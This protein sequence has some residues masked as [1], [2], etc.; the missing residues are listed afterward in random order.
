M[1]TVTDFQSLLGRVCG[2]EDLSAD[3]MGQALEAMFQ[4][5]MPDGQIGLFLSALTSKGETV[6]ELVGA[7]TCLRRHMTRIHSTHERFVDTCG[8]GGDGLGTFNVSTAAAIV[9]A[10]AGLPVAKHGNRKVTSK[11]G[12]ADVLTQLGV[13]I[14]AGVDVVESCLR[15]LGICFCFAPLLHP[16]LARVA[17]VRRQLGVPTI[18]NLLGP[19]ANPASAPFQLLGVGREN[20]RPL[21]ANALARL[22]VRRALVVWGEDGLDEVT[23]SAPTRVS[24]VRDG[25]VH[26]FVWTAADFGVREAPLAAL[27]VEG[28]AES[29]AMIHHVLSGGNGAARNI[30]LVN[31]AA[32]LWVAGVVDSLPAGVSRAA[33]AIDEGHAAQLIKRLAAAT[34]PTTGP[35]AA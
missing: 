2:G 29:A 25:I 15:E 26:E 28:P 17:A 10:A 30:V 13:T 9:T 35:A 33:K 14:E 23:L 27:L 4:G 1:A 18:F 7:A 32:A 31:S 21:L 3:G 5:D 19:L 20:L 34:N 11:T 12:S 22:G 16:S 24:E 8:T 6:D